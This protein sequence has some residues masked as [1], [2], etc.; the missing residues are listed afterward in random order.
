VPGEERFT[1]RIASMRVLHLGFLALQIRAGGWVD[2]TARPMFSNLKRHLRIED[3]LAKTTPGLA[4]PM[5]QRL[6][7]LRSASTSTPH[8]ASIACTRRPMTDA[9]STSSL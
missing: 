5:V 3:H 4:Q 1:Q 8:R 9:E 7:A 2:L 6:L